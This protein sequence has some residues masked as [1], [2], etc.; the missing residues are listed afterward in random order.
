MI[1]KVFS[2]KFLVGFTVL[3]PSILFMQS[4]LIINKTW[5]IVGIFCW[6]MGL[7][8]MGLRS[9]IGLQ[10]ALKSTIE[11]AVPG[12][13]RLQ[14]KLRS[15]RGSSGELAPLS[16]KPSSFWRL[17]LQKRSI[18]NGKQFWR[19]VSDACSEPFLMKLYDGSGECYILPSEA[20]LQVKA[21]QKICSYK[22][23]K[24]LRNAY[25]QINIC[26]FEEYM[27]IRII[28]KY[29]PI[30]SNLIC[31]GFLYRQSLNKNSLAK[32]IDQKLQLLNTDALDL[33]E[34]I[35]R[36]EEEKR[37]LQNIC[38]QHMILEEGN[39]INVPILSSTGNNQTSQTP[40]LITT[41]SWR[42][43]IFREITILG[44]YIV[45]L[46]FFLLLV[47]PMFNSGTL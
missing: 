23:L 46:V 47:L 32:F 37:A 3:V 1:N 41:E 6:L 2:I 20:E 5:F 29:L 10:K 22:E 14:G 35:E 7:V 25:P 34:Y 36:F 39:T 19:T 26:N 21:N 11:T 12:K 30:E 31:S 44:L 27:D 8:Y 9:V 28:E 13:V 33:D 18:I 24:E 42:E 16:C 15:I 43:L 4:G 45:I 17:Q 38:T 40:L